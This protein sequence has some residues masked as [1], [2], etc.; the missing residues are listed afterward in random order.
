MKKIKKSIKNF[1]VDVKNTFYNPKFYTKIKHKDWTA[2]FFMIIILSLVSSAILLVSFAPDLLKFSDEINT[3]EIA[4]IF[5]AELEIVVKNGVATSNVEEPYYFGQIAKDDNIKVN[6]NDDKTYAVVV[7]TK[8]SITLEEARQFDAYLIIGQNA[9]IGEENNELKAYFYSDIFQ[10]NEFTLNQDLIASW[11]DKIKI[12]IKPFFYLIATVG[13][14][15]MTVFFSV[16]WFFLALI[17][18]AATL[19]IMAIKDRHIKYGQAYKT[20]LYGLVPVII[21]SIL[22]P[23]NP[24]W[25]K[26]LLFAIVIWVNTEKK[27]FG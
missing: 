15:F 25:L 14:L 12:W 11:A 23:G 17:F 2:P 9:L 21:V 18:S 4:Q 5:P 8:E 1:F 3:G 26:L 24:I 10:E 16:G 22:V 20:T 6:G 7:N 27:M 19:L 13:F